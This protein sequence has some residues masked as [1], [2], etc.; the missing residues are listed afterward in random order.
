MV[1][2]DPAMAAL[3]APVTAEHV[4]LTYSH[5][6]DLAL[7]N[8]LLERGFSRCGLIGS[9]TKWARF[10]RRLG[11]LG[12]AE[13][14]IARISCPIGDPRL[15]KHPQAIAV[16]VAAELLAPRAAGAGVSAG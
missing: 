5:A 7:C 8:A 6:L 13:A 4:I 16:G 9:A 1:A 3:H 15:G 12:H 11:E 10:R 14:E 2:A